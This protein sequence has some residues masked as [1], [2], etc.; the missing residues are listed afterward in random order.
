MDY[1]AVVS[2]DAIRDYIG[3]AS[4]VAFDFETA[5]LPAYRDEDR[6]ALDA[7]MAHIVGISLSVSEGTAVYIPLRHLAGDNADPVAVMGFLRAA[8]FENPNVTK[9]AHNLAFEGMFLYALGIVVQP[10]CYDTIAASQLTLKG[11]AQFRELSDSG[12]KRLA[13]SLLGANVTT[14]GEATQGQHFDE[15]DAQSPEAIR[16][17]CADSDYTLQLY[18]KFNA[19]FDAYLPKHR[20]IVEQVES[21]TAVYCGLMK[22]NGV[23]MDSDTMQ[24]KREEAEARRE[25]LRALIAGIIGDVDIGANASTAAFKRHLFDTMGLPVLKTTATNKEA[26]DDQ[27]MMM[28]AEWCAAHR[29]ELVPLFELVQEYRKLG[30]IAATYI[31]GYLRHLNPV[32]GCVHPD[33]MP[34]ATETGRFA[35]RRPNLQNCFDPLT[36]ILTPRG[37]VPFP[38]L[39]QRDKVAQW[40][41]GEISFV[42]PDGII[43]QEYRGEMIHVKSDHTDLFMTPDH[44]CLV[45]DRKTR[46]YCVFPASQY[47]KEHKQLHAA[48]YHF[49][50]KRLSHM[51]IVLLT[52]T[53]ADGYFHDGGIE[54]TFTKARK[55]RRLVQTL[56]ASGVPY[57]DSVKGDGSVRVRILKGETSDWLRRELGAR[58]SWGRWLLAYD[59]QTVRGILAEIMHWDGCFT[60]TNHYS[61][62]IKENADWMQVLYALTGHR[63]HMRE[64]ESANPKAAI[65]YQL[66]V[67]EKDFSLTGSAKIT[68]YPYEGMVYCVSVPSGYIMVRRG[69]QVSI[70]GNCPRKDNDPV[71]VRSFIVAPMGKALLSLDFSQIELR[72]GAFYCR[73]DNM[74][75][76]YKQ[77]GDIHAQTTAIVYGIP[78]EQAVDKNADHYKE[79]RTIAKN[80]NFGICFNLFAKGLQRNLRF[81]AGLSKSLGECEQIIRNLK[82]GYPLLGRWQSKAIDRAKLTRYTE[83]WL[84]RR[85]YLPGIASEDWSK[86]SYAE[87]CS[88]NSPIQGTAADIL[89]L[90]LGRI[91]RGLP[92]RLWLRPLLQIHDEIV[93]ELPADK[94]HEAVAFVKEC[95]EARPFPEFDVPIVAEASYGLNFGDMAEMES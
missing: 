86:R 17:A 32:T 16:Y 60:R 9:V 29:P 50:E 74:L 31:D 80:C 56:E 23:R 54:F 13:A 70:T 73:D 20:V 27:T 18:H 72:V 22:Y 15:L 39:S 52:A 61:S 85:R 79:R 87:R 83:T 75:E 71:G 78:F 91:V 59:R 2:M 67:S 82:A 6:A 40:R 81:K 3:D 93:F 64:Y 24:Y 90:A 94:L 95:M 10:P 34:L 55:Y 66:D 14:F 62:S 30:K 89:K 43:M 33:L 19:W 37:F 12:L 41:D 46:Q 77:G 42:E 35:S 47:P 28:L 63:A 69:G 84:G 58:K 88:L 57:S 26:A 45:Q 51:G 21:P 25:D 76:T 68:R 11:H 65:N 92:E 5:P 44:R 53:Q 7:H 49:G 8:V 36:E 48:Q 38:E 4:I 1:K